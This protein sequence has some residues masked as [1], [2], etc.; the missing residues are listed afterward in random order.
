MTYVNNNFNSLTLQNY[1]DVLPKTNTFKQVKQDSYLTNC[2]C[3]EDRNPS[4][5][6][7]QVNHKVLFKC[8]AGCP[9]TKLLEY[10]SS[11]LGGQR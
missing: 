4:M 5:V 9:Q 2:P 1:L 10:F 8:F 6:I 3:H 7:S 11:E